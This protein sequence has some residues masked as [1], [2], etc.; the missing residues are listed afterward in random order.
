[1]VPIPT[2]AGRLRINCELRRRQ[3]IVVG[4]DRD[5]ASAANQRDGIAPPL[6]QPKAQIRR[7][8]P[9]RCGRE[10]PLGLL[11]IRQFLLRLRLVLQML[12]PGL[13]P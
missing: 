2:L 10:R 7:P 9:L 1:M 11:G 8:A 13:A 3:P 12:L 5:R 6:L 4:P